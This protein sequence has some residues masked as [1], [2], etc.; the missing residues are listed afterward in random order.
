VPLN[1]ERG[2]PI[3]RERFDRIVDIMSVVLISLSTILTAWCGYEAA[4]WSTLAT[5]SYNEANA[6][7]LQS[8][9]MVDRSTGLKVID[10]SLFLQYIIAE[11]EHHD[12]VRD[13]IYRRF[14]AEIQPAVKAW[15]ATKPRTNP[16]APTS[17][18]VMP[19]YR[20]AADVAAEQLDATA[21]DLF[22]TAGRAAETGD[23]Y[24]R[25]TVAFAA[26]SFLAGISTKFRFPYHAV[27]V[28]GGFLMLIYGGIVLAGSPPR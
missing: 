9:E 5:Q 2:A 10:V 18:F 17:P 24:V 23:D 13:F 15:L 26:V 12:E 14:R 8:S 16:H 25:L 28:S 22:S 27:I 11:D 1:N 4:R 3:A 20:L 6:A 19:Q 7:R 21:K